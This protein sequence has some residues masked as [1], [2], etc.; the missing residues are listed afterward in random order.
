M[1]VLMIL[2]A[3]RQFIKAAAV[4]RALKVREDI[5][6]AMRQQQRKNFWCKCNKHA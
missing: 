3:R 5:E 2:G 6:M 1:K 4:S